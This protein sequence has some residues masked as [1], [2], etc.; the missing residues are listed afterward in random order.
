M[1]AKAYRYVR[2]VFE[3]QL[4]DPSTIRSWW[5]TINGRPGITFQAINILKKKVEEAGDNT[6]YGCLSM[7]E[8]SIRHQV[9]WDDSQK[10]FVGLVNHGSI[11]PPPVHSPNTDESTK[12]NKPPRTGLKQKAPNGK[13]SKKR[14]PKTKQPSKNAQSNENGASEKFKLPIAKNALVYLVTGINQRWKIPVAYLLVN[15]LTAT[16]LA[17]ITK[18]VLAFI[19][20]SGIHIMGLTFD[21]LPANIAMASELGADINDGATFP[22]PTQNHNISIFLD[23]AHMLKLVRN[24]LAQ[25]NLYD[26]KDEKISFEYFHHLVELQEQGQFHLANRLNRMHTNWQNN[27]MNVKLATQLL[28]DS[29]YISLQQLQ[30]DNH[31][32]FL[33]CGATAEFCKMIND[34]FDCL[35]SRNLCSYGLKKPLRKESAPEILKFIARAQEYFSG[36]KIEV[37]SHIADSTPKKIPILES[38]CKTGFLGLILDLKNLQKMYESYVQPGLLKYI[39]TYKF[40]QDHLEILFSCLRSHG[41]YNN[42]PN[43]SQFA[44]AYKRILVHNEVKSSMGANCVTLDNTSILQVSSGCK[45][46]TPNHHLVSLKDDSYSN[47]FIDVDDIPL[48]H[49][50]PC[51]DHVVEYLTGFVQKKLYQK[52][53]CQ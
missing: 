41:G 46:T 14:K 36:I 53:D 5:A 47:V 38:N 3:N 51:L 37:I 48:S 52:I 29:C 6:I 27:K 9:E 50:D 17:N 12:E 2:Q 30:K 43:A 45:K 22:H 31:P 35:N 16:Q 21:G 23:A 7:D 39:M 28:S 4:P 34:V 20:E 32:K 11:I 19:A 25:H 24:T 33:K 18:E 49:I 15:G 10:R 42:N 26:H 8:M 40:S 44:A 1:Y 13:K